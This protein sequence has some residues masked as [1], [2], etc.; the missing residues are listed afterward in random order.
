MKKQVLYIHGGDSFGKYEDFLQ[1][2]RTKTVR[3]P[4]GIER[5]SIWVENFRENLGD[6]EVLMPKMPNSQN[7]Q[8]EEWKVWFERYFEFLRDDVVLV[9]WS[10]GGMFLAKYLSE[11]KFPVKIKAVYLLGAPSGEFTDES[12]NDCVSF[13]FSMENLANLTRQAEE[14]NVWH[15]KDDF[16]VPFEEFDLY[17][18]FAPEAKFVAFVDK[19]HFLIPEFP[20]LIDSIKSI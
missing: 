4:F 20:E 14:V 15:S 3:D 17:K 18:K 16:I 13:K 1:D 9:G 8:Y 7:A 6:L 12:G 11:E 5:K 19:N 10:L 2:L